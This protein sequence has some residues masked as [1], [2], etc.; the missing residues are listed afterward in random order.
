MR[1]SAVAMTTLLLGAAL[2]G[3]SDDKPAV[4]DSV[5]TLKSSIEDVKNIDVTSSSAVSDLESRLNT[6]KSDLDAVKTDAK[7]EYASQVDAV[8]SAF[9]TLTTSVDAAK[10]DPSATTLAA[11]G[12]AVSPF[13]TAV[14]TLSDDVQSTC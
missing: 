4:C 11:V 8:E 6:I 7:S 12:A 14:Q 3:C 10:A 9:T 5:D 2:V 13:T 1:L